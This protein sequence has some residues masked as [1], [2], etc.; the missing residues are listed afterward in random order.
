MRMR[1]HIVQTAK[2]YEVK[3]KSKKHKNM[4]ETYISPNN[5]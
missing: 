3:R 4:I 5:I 2:I 1:A